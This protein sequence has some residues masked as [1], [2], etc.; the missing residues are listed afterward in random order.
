MFRPSVYD[1]MGFSR[2]YMVFLFRYRL[3]S[4]LSFG[5]GCENFF[6]IRRV[7]SSTGDLMRRVGY[8]FGV[9]FIRGF[10]FCCSDYPELFTCLQ[11]QLGKALGI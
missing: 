11:V 10:F 4:F 6:P 9:C 5:G 7:I 2:F 3:A 1:R 8:V